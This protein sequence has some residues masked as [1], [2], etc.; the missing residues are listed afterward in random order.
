[1]FHLHRGQVRV[2]YWLA[3]G[4]RVLLMTV[5]AKTRQREQ[6]EVERARAAQQAC[7]QGHAAGH[8]GPGPARK[9]YERKWD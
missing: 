7:D 3:P 6:G 5:F 1:V 2:S 8:P 9:I 4:Q